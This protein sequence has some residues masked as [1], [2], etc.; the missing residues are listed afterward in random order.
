MIPSDL[1]RPL[2]DLAQKF[3]DS[4]LISDAR[5]VLDKLVP[6]EREIPGDNG[7]W[8][9]RRA[10]PYRTADNRIDGV[11]ITF[12]DITDRKNAEQTVVAAHA[13]SQAVLEQMPAAVLVVD[14]ASGKLL[15]ANHRVAA[16][17]GSPYPF[18]WSQRIGIR[19]LRDSRDV[20][21]MVDPTARSSGRSPGRWRRAK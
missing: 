21:P 13:W 17:F 3:T 15:L 10:L 19:S 1:G 14:A 12:V 11:V 18:R 6:I 16:L 8:Y 7:A 2:S 4:D 9:V 20:F 5:S